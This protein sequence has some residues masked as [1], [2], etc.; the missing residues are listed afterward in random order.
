L[1]LSGDDW[2][3]DPLVAALGLRARLRRDGFDVRGRVGRQQVRI[4]VDLPESETVD[5]DYRDPDGA[6]LLC[7][8]S[9]R[10]TA[11]VELSRRGDVERSWRLDGV[12][13]AEVGGFRS[14]RHVP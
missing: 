8:N 12:A 2:P 11:V 14:N 10:A 1:R 3:P 4:S 13:H 9:A 6:S 7:R 5:V